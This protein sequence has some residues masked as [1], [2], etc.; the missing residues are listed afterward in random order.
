MR[1]IIVTAVAAACFVAAA[2]ALPA[3]LVVV[4]DK[5]VRPDEAAGFYYLGTCAAG[6]LYNGSSAA[7][8]RAAP[9][10]VLDRDAQRKDYYIV[11]AP[12][13]VNVKA[14]AFEHLGTSARLSEYE[15]LVGLELG[16]GPGALRAVEHRIELIK[17]APVTP[18]EWSY[19]AEAP[20][21][22]KDPVI[23]AAVNTITEAEYAGYIKQ[24]QDFRTRYTFTEGCEG[25]G[26]YVRN[27]FASQNLDATLFP[28]LCSYFSGGHYPAVGGNIYLE[29]RHRVL[30]RSK[31]S[32]GSWDN[33]LP[34]GSNGLAAVSW[35]DGRTGFVAGYDNAL[36]KTRDGGDTWEKL[37]F[38]RGHPGWRYYPYASYFLTEELGWLGGMAVSPNED[39]TG[40]LIMTSDGGLTWSEQQL[41]ERF[42]PGSIRFYNSR[43]GWAANSYTNFEPTFIYTDDGGST[44]R[45]CTDPYSGIA[46]GIDLAAVGGKEAWAAGDGG[47]LL[48]T[49]DGLNWTYVSVPVSGP[50]NNVEFPE[51]DYGY[52]GGSTLIA[53]DDGGVTWHEVKEA[54]EMEYDL[55]AFAGRFS[56]VAGCRTGEDL[57]RTDDGCKTFVDISAGAQL[58]ADNVI[59]ERLGCEA[60]DE[61]VIIGGHFDSYSD[62]A[63]RACPGAEDNASGTA[64]AMAAARAFRGMSFKRTVR[65]VAF[66]DE[67]A[68]LSG[69]RAYANECAEKGEKI[70]A[71]LNADMVSYDEEEGARD[72]LTVGAPGYAAWLV[73]YLQAVGGL[74]S[75]K[76][77]YDWDRN[78]VSDDR[79]FVNAG[80]AA[81]GVIEGGEGP[82]GL[83][84]YPFIHTTEDT[85]DKL[86][87][88]FGARCARDLAATLAHLAGVGDYC[89]EPEPPGKV[90]AP[91]VRPF[92]VYPNPYCYAT[93]VGGVS[94]VGVKSPAT[95]EIYDLAGRRV[96]REEV[97]AGC[98][99]CVWRPATAE[100]ET[101]APGVYLYRV[102]GQ[103]QKEAGKVV[104][105]R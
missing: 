101:L 31:D 98:D 97:S 96:G 99:E 87:P 51:R 17:L 69:S 24:L 35:V 1:N 63:P 58:S 74:Y 100:G 49:T 67:E 26:N 8:G 7:V 93:C 85:F 75:Q 40:F 5:E 60:P 42:R 25:A 6:Y 54:P 57:Y 78:S 11:W 38:G 72:D 92:A 28:F 95:V 80:Y 88:A 89:F 13:W 105:A 33:V 70:V 2:Y 21:K 12:A 32:G 34:G 39:Y 15:I 20:P 64:C 90:V 19:D 10:R 91:F 18:V 81:L 45:P 46:Y 30:R 76:L 50:F 73:E 66:G 82:G 23:E 65:Y 94:F 4:S 14:E 48:H 61:V 44:W 86:Q 9:Y 29:E 41:P 77:I 68:G 3:D 71:V 27:F 43:C 62:A 37:V 84:G 83:L 53:T 102:E 36:Y 55:L 79:S 22:K 47:N 104:V 56:G 16:L 52:A 59:G 103:E